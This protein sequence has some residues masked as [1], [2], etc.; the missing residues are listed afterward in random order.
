MSH[1]VF[2]WLVEVAGTASDDLA[3]WSP[4][5]LLYRGRVAGD[6]TSGVDDCEGVEAV[7]VLAVAAGFTEAGLFVSMVSCG[8]GVPVRGSL[9]SQCCCTFFVGER[10]W[11]F[12]INFLAVLRK[13]VRCGGRREMWCGA[14]SGSGYT[15]GHY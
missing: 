7:E 2:C 15:L 13:R 8:W 10:C 12:G 11:R 14:A 9:D 6:L 5:L 4:S 1:L 3:R